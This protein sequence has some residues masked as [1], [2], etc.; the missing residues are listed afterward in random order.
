[1]GVH[2][3][4]R[5][6]GPLVA[7]LHRATVEAM[8]APAMREGLLRLEM[9]PAVLSP[10]ALAQRIRTEREAWGPIVRASGFAADE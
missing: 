4:A 3:P 7:A 5:V 1:M 6:P 2:L 9:T 8:E 10:A